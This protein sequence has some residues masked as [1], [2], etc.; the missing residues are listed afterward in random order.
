MASQ[1]K[2]HSSGI[3]SVLDQSF[4][5][6]VVQRHGVLGERALMGADASSL[7][8]QQQLADAFMAS[9]HGQ[10]AV[11]E[12]VN[13]LVHASPS[14]LKHEFET[15]QTM[16]NNQQKNVIHEAQ[17]QDKA[18]ILNQADERHLIKTQDSALQQAHELRKEQ[19]DNLVQA[20]EHQDQATKNPMH[21]AQNELEKRHKQLKEGY[22]HNQRFYKEGKYD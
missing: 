18:S 2:E 20:Y 21:T 13:R 12:Q 16:M 14:H 22:L 11:K 17:S 6:W 10:N 7:H 3:D 4:H 1:V 5:D 19:Q 8:T 15:Q 9:S